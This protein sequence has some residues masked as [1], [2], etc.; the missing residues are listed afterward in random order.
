[1]T[2]T[3]QMRHRFQNVGA[4]YTSSILGLPLQLFAPFGL[5][6]ADWGTQTDEEIMETL[7]D[8]DEAI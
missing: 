4:L 2:R 1:M 8:E 5:I 7:Y 6:P 3:M